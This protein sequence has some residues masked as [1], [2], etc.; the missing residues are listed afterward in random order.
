VGIADWTEFSHTT[1]GH[2]DA[3]ISVDPNELINELLIS[4]KGLEEAYPRTLI[5]KILLFDSVESRNGPSS[6][7]NIIFVPPVSQQRIT[8]IKTIM[9]DVTS[10]LVA[11]MTTLAISIQALPSIPSPSSNSLANGLSSNQWYND[12]TQGQTRPT[13]QTGERPRSASP[14]VNN[15]QRMSLPVFPSSGSNIDSLTEIS[16][17][18]TPESGYNTPPAKTF[19]EISSGELKSSQAS[20]S[21][22]HSRDR[23]SVHG[24]GPGSLNE[25]NRNK[26]KARVAL[27]I[28]SLYLQAGQWNDA[29]RELSEGAAKARSFSDHLWHAKALENVMLCMILLAWSRADF[30]VRTIS[31]LYHRFSFHTNSSR[32]HRYAILY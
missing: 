25:R 23:V 14:A 4:L 12:D 1:N 18:T 3:G 30:T 2:G 11:E 9:C 13:S 5:Q 26:G 21:R 22:Q 27:V 29:L 31:P 20:I 17:T 8:T 7:Q 19:D 28:G 24:F 15:V 32:F 10:A 16:R 6:H